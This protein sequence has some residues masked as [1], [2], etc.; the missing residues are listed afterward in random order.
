MTGDDKSLGERLKIL[1]ETW[2][3]TQEDMSVL[4][5][6]VLRS[7]QN[8]ERGI[9]QPRSGDITALA[10][11]NVDLNWL[12]TGKGEMFS[13]DPDVRHPLNQKLMGLVMEG[14]KHVYKEENARIDNRSSGEVAAKIYMETLELCRGSTEI[15]DQKAALHL[16]LSHLRRALRS[17]DSK[18]QR[19]A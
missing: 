19:T 9:R 8:Y 13:S 18:V 2:K 15:E 3:L 12:L 14:V 11:R 1:R 17:V 6:I 16:T 4:M 10:A 7:Y 5:N